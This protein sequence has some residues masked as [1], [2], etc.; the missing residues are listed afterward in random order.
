M[1][2]SYQAKKNKTKNNGWTMWLLTGALAGLLFGF[3][4]GPHIIENVFP[5]NWFKEG[6]MKDVGFWYLYT[7]ITTVLGSIIGICSYQCVNK[8]HS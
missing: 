7:L 8:K 6:E 1:A 5:D 4:S 2:K 3:F